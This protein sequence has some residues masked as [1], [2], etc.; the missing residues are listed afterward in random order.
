Q[1]LRYTGT[2]GAFIDVFA[3]AGGLGG[4]TYL[5]FRRTDTTT[6]VNASVN[7]V[8]FGQPAAFTATVNSVVPTASLPTGTVIFTIDGIAQSPPALS[9][10]Q[11]SLSVP[12]LSVGSHVVTAAYNGD[13]G[14]SASTSV[15]LNEAVN[16]AQTITA[17]SASPLSS[18]F[19]QLIRFTAAVNVV[20]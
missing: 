4:P 2:T 14:F 1:V 8:V 12:M 3:S 10:G 18:V 17:V 13:L 6:T 19:G 20:A 9:N 5:L 15:P 11:A 16:K 7:P